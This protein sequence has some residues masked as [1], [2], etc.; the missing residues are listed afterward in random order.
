MQITTNNA[1]DSEPMWTSDS[2]NIVF[3]SYREKSKDIFI[4]SCE[5]G[6]PKRLTFHPGH[7]TLRAV[8]PDGKIIFSANIQQDVTF[9]GFPGEAQLYYTDTEGSRPVRITSLPIS[10]ISINKKGDILYE[11]WKGYEDQFRKHHTSAVTRDIWL[12]RGNSAGGKLS[13]NAEGTF[14]KLSDYAGEDRNPVFGP[15]GDTFYYLS[16]R[17]GKSMNIYKSSISAPE[18][19]VQLT[20]ETRN[21]VRYLSVADNGTLTYS[22][23]GSLYTLKEGGKPEKVAIS[24]YSDQDERDIER[25]TLSG[26]ASAVAVSPDQKEV[27]LVIRGDVF[28]TSADYKTTKRITNTAA[29]ER[30]VSFSEDGRTIYYAA[31]RDGNWG[32]WRTSLVNKEDKRFAYAT[33]FKEELFSDKGETC[34]QPQVSPDGKYVAYLRD[35]TELVIKPTKGGKTISLLKGVNY[36]YADGDISFEWSPDSHYLLSTYEAEGRWNNCDIAL[37]DIDT[38]EVTDLTESGYND[39]AF[40]WALGGKAMVWQSDKDGYRS[41]GSWGAETDIYIMF[42]DAKT[43]T[44]FFRDK[45]GDEIAKLMAGDE[46]KAKKEDKTEKKDSTD[47]KK[48]TKL[49]LDLENR[50]D[51][52]FR[53]TRFSG[54]LGDH[55]LSKDG[56]KLFYEV[57]LESSYDLCVR[58]MKEGNVKVLKKGVMGNIIPSSD[59]SYI[60]IPSAG[61]ISRMSVSGSEGKTITYSGEYEFKPKAEREYI[62]DHMWKQVKEKFY[63]PELHGVDW[64]YYKENYSQFLPYI[65][66]NFDFQELMSEILGELNASHTGARFQYR[67]GLN[68]G[69]LGVL[70]DEDYEG[71]GLKIKEVLPDGALSLAY[72]EIKEGDIIASIDGKEIKDLSYF[73]TLE[74]IMEKLNARR[75]AFQMPFQIK[76]GIPG[77]RISFEKEPSLDVGLWLFLKDGTH[78]R[79]QPVITEAKM[80]VGGMRVDKNSVL[81]KGL[82][83]ATVGLATER[84]SYIDTVTETVKKILNGEEVADYIAPEAPVETKDWMTTFLL[85]LFCGGLGIHRYYVGKIGTGILYTLTLGLFGIG[86]LVDFI[87]ILCGKFTDKNGNYIQR[88][89][90]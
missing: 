87:K 19:S 49:K 36:S 88:A 55:Y 7:E 33:E 20:F 11:D 29:Q 2:K 37:I 64:E 6:T 35:R 58:D 82:K 48:A 30:G 80:S 12:Y 47:K 15:D 73:T 46:K 51:R 21:P 39:G 8:L 32:I 66:N 1:Y 69:N 44:E 81:R 62:F 40:R 9:D 68:M 38:K 4:T 16:E 13:I 14:K 77:Q 67:S 61:G 59:E 26:G 83:G 23:N 31:E 60:Y 84:G 43:M 70:Y 18:K 78:I 42:F 5:G 54:R 50:A 27:A 34:F 10:E 22:Y 74:E 56:K 76:G 25:L 79:I 90:K 17:D 3:T 52:T 65:N 57:R 89:K 53:L 72:P 41:H 24:V 75:A 28:V 63:D 85:C 71:D 86:Y 45:E